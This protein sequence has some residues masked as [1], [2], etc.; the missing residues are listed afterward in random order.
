M[1]IVNTALSDT[2]DPVVIR[3]ANETSAILTALSA[4]E[5]ITLLRQ[6]YEDD[7]RAFDDQPKIRAQIIQAA[8][9]DHI[10]IA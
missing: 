1:D 6:A 3:I 10:D 9:Q 2:D 5:K 8:K 7:A 4:G